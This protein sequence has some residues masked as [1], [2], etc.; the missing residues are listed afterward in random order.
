[1]KIVRRVTGLDHTKN[2]SKLMYP[3][4]EE[5]LVAQPRDEIDRARQEAEDIGK[6]CIRRNGFK[7]SGEYHQYGAMF[8]RFRT[9]DEGG[10]K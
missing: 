8:C 9:G 7:F 6:A 2:P 4:V 5:N 3:A 1:M 10:G